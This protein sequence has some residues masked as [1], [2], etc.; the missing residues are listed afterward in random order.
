MV[1][2]VF[3]LFGSGFEKPKK[4]IINKANKSN[5]WFRLLEPVWI[6]VNFG[7]LNFRKMFE[8]PND[9]IACDLLITDNFI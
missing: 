8:I 2:V 4:G 6:I 9:K 1:L 7:D 3:E 5:G